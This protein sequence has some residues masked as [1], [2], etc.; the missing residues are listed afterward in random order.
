M[1]KEMKPVLSCNLIRSGS[2]LLC[3]SHERSSTWRFATLE[4]VLWYTLTY[5]INQ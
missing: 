3:G 4:V 5:L 2:E 1:C